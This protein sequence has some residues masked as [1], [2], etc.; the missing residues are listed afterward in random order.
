LYDFENGKKGYLGEGVM[1]GLSI[2]YLWPLG[3]HFAIEAEAGGG[4]MMT[5]YKEYIPYEGHHL[6]VRTQNMN[7]FG[8]LKL[9]LAIVW[10]LG[11]KANRGEE[12]G[13]RV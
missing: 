11:H 7:F 1:S 5:R 9:K 8:P 4:W 3:R 6:Y 2:G 12:K 10:L 13:D